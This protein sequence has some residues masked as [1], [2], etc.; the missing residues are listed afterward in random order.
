MPSFTS[1]LVSPLR[2]DIVSEAAGAAVGESADAELAALLVDY[3]ALYTGPS[4]AR[5]RELFLPSFVATATNDDGTVSAWNLDTFYERQRNAFATGKP[6]RET[7]ENTQV[8][9]TGALASV[10][11][12]FVWTDGTITRRGRLMLLVIRE[13]GRFRIQALTFSYQT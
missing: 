8:D 3:I 5:W 7:L 11:S 2:R 13:R 6:I 1:F 12:E 9:C 10:R 4:L